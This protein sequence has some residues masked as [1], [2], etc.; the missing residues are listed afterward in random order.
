[1]HWTS[2]GELGR[3]LSEGRTLSV[4]LGNNRDCSLWALVEAERLCHR[5]RRGGDD[6]F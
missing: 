6:A 5:A 1:M 2:G 4:R 3:F